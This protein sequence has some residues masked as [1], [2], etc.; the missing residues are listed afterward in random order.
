[1]NNKDLLDGIITFSPDGIVASD[2]RGVIV[3]FNRAAEKMTG[4]QAGEVTNLLSI[5]QIF[6]QLRSNPGQ[7]GPGPFEEKE[8]EF[9]TREGATLPIKVLT[10]NIS[11]NGEVLGKISM[12]RD[13]SQIKNFEKKLRDISVTD[14]LTGLFNRRHFHGLLRQEAHRAQRYDRPL[15][16]GCLDLDHFQALNQTMG[17]LEGDNAL[18]FVAYFLRESLRKMD[19]IFRYGGDEFM[20]IMPETN[21]SQ[22]LTGLKRLR[23]DF[24]AQQAV[25]SKKNGQNGHFKPVTF[26]MGV[27]QLEPGESEESL[28]KRAEQAMLQASATG[29]NRTMDAGAAIQ[30]NL[31]PPPS[32]RPDPPA[33]VLTRQSEH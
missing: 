17:Q 33:R 4:Y 25:R 28:V 11:K 16:L 24:N 13:L 2:E 22:A 30:I 9:T 15:S 27:A 31:V 5:E 32:G 8:L 21:L 19:L 1:M 20:I 18:R 7:E 6:R 3:L 14:Q 26:S 29:G 12:L 23:E 10:S